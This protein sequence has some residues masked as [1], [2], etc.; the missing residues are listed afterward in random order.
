M[1]KDIKDLNPEVEMMKEKENY[2][3]GK[4]LSYN[5]FLVMITRISKILPSLMNKFVKPL[6]IT[7]SPLPHPNQNPIVQ[8]AKD[9]SDCFVI[10]KYEID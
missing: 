1:L 3:L 7:P 8:L 6:S 10:N 4:E 5:K 2:I 9:I